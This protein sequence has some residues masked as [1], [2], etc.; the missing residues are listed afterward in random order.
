MSEIINEPNV[1]ETKPDAPSA[2][3]TIV[4]PSET[5]AETGKTYSQD[6]INDIIKDRLAR[7]KKKYEGFDELKSKLSEYE[8]KAEEQRL[9][10]LSEVER[11]NELAKQYEAQLAELKTE[12]EAKDNAVR[13]QTIKSEFIKVATSAN[14]IDI[15]AAIALS[16]L[17]AVSI[18]EAG[19]VVGVDDLV[20][21]LVDNKP[22]LVSKKITQPIGQPSNGST[23][24]NDKSADQLL[25]EAEAKARKGNIKDRMAYAKLKRELNR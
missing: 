4:T 5:P 21:S 24:P 2:T 17:S 3:E 20:K 22:Y 15:D 12:I 11:A 23:V 1:I 6:E 25:A 18:D 13:T 8:T 9:A 14:I 16:D 7:E 10:Q 19:K